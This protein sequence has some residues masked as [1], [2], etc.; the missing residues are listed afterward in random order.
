[1]MY[2]PDGISDIIHH[3]S[4]I[5]LQACRPKVVATAVNT[6]ITIFKI[7]LHTELWFSL[8]IVSLGFSFCFLF[9]FHHGVHG[10]PQ[11]FSFL[12]ISRTESS[13]TRQNEAKNLV[14]ISCVCVRDPSLHSVSLWMTISPETLKELRGTPCYSVVNK[15]RGE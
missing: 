1:M 9:F 13:T 6:V 4:Y 15:I 10:V 5:Q 8:F 7:L 3:T 12:V 2:H 14:D 11:S